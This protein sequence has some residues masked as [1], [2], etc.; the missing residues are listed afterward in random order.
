MANKKNQDIQDINVRV[1][2]APSPTGWFHIGTARTALFNYLFARQNK[3]K[4]ILR[5]EDTDL[6]RS[7]KKYEKDIIESLK[8]LGLDWDEGPF[9]QTARTEIYQK[10]IEQLLRAG[11]AFWCYH[12]KE[13]LETEK[14]RQMVRKEAPRHLCE[15]KEN[16]PRQ[17]SEKGIIR[18]RCA[19]KKIKFNDLIR[20]ALEF[21]AKLLGDISIARDKKT[22][23]YNFAVVVDDGEMEI[24]HI[25]RGEDH[26]SNTPKQILLAEALG[27]E[28]PRF[29]HLPLILG[30]DRNKLSKRHAAVAISDYRQEGYL[31]SALI[32][33]MALLGWNPGT[34]KEIFSLGELVRE[35]SLKR[36]QKSGAV[37]DI[38]RL[39][40]INGCY[41]R[42]M[43]LEELSQKCLP[44]LKL[45][46]QSSDFFDFKHIKKIISLEQER[47]KKLSEIGELTTFFFKDQLDYEP[48]LLIW[49]N[50]TPAQIKTNL[51]LLYEKLSNLSNFSLKKL[52]R[53]IMPLT[54]KQGTG[55]LLWPLRVALSGQKA[56]PGPLEI[57]EIL[58]QERTL[59]R[60]KEAINKL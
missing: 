25:I 11:Q 12:S 33:F 24:S 18:F 39:D 10:Y 41:I 56:S 1:R 30:P 38:K 5:I 59:K 48:E 17:N 57:A 49:K 42:Q 47:L 19:D 13:E 22:P 44:Y 51:E 6:E 21:D 7:D 37:F 16:P 26:L 46:I 34:E 20:G 53:T 2:I 58:G 40:W 52:E 14:K 50:T 9:S 4:F 15:H 60:I 36:I 55:E 54:E 43:D 8:W 28:S 31:P 3:G 35:F 23:L 45:Q 29:A 32:N 27:F